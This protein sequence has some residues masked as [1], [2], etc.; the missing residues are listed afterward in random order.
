M[1]NDI[2][3][4]TVLV[5]RPL[6]F[7]GEPVGFIFCVALIFVFGVGLVL[8]LI[9]WLQCKF[10]IYTVT[11]MRVV[12][13]TGILSRNT[14]EVRHKDVRNL[15]VYQGVLRTWLGTGS[16]AISSAG[17]SD[18]ELTMKNIENPHKIAG[19][20]RKYQS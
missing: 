13:Q 3:E 12:E 19:I 16:V 6:M 4:E 8:L 14:N 18:I 17:Q 9:W 20:I 2:K 7:R 15:K 1:A 10:T 11:S 5:I